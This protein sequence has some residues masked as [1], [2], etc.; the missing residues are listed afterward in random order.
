M[1][2]QNIL[3]AI[4]KAIK[5]IVTTVYF[6]PQGR[7]RVGNKTPFVLI[8]KGNETPAEVQ[9]KM[10]ICKEIE[11]EILLC[12]DSPTQAETIRLQNLIEAA[13]KQIDCS[14]VANLACIR[15]AG[16]EVPT[17]DSGGDFFSFDT[18]NIRATWQLILIR[19]IFVVH[20]PN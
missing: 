13:I 9:V 2:A 5:P 6:H 3:R 14:S 19:Y 17:A 15:W 12:V 8:R 7:G 18:P 20:Q 11:Y 16:V 1:T 10:K 4:E